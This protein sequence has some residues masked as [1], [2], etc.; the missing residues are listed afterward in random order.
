[1]TNDSSFDAENQ[2][3]FN[4]RAIE[5]RR[6]A[7]KQLDMQQTMKVGNGFLA[8]SQTKLKWF[9]QANVFQKMNKQILLYFYGTS[10]WLVF[11]RFLEEIEDTKKIFRH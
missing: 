7:Q 6:A 4:F 11:I 5:V 9:F 3:T 1:M 8:K 10:G 2:W